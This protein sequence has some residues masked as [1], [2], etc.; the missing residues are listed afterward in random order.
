MGRG[1]GFN[2]REVEKGA[3]APGGHGRGK[4]QHWK[5]QWRY[6]TLNDAETE[7]AVVVSR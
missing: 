4:Q 3:A 1:G 7:G 5:L 6:A 2:R